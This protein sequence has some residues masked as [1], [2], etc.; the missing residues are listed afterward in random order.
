MRSPLLLVALLLLASPSRAW[1]FDSEEFFPLEVGNFWT[2]EETG[3]TP[4]TST[5]AS[6]QLVSGSMTFPVVQSGGSNPGY[7]E[8]CTNDEAGLRIHRLHDPSLGGGTIIFNPPFVMAPAHAD[9]GDPAV[10]GFGGAAITIAGLGSWAFWYS[11]SAAVVGRSTFD[12]PEYGT[13]DTVE[14]R[15]I[16][17][18]YGSIPNYGSISITQTNRD[19][20]ARGVGFVSYTRTVDG[21]TETGTLIAT[22]APEPTAAASAL[23]ALTVLFVARRRSRQ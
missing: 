12:F 16:L 22:N 17:T 1:D 6:G 9:V 11:S 14:V 18:V 15:S 4:T 10:T 2:H 23:A 13:L 19:W 7:F 3:T 8:N 21:E 5:V 20:Y